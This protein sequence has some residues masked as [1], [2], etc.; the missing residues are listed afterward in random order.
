MCPGYQHHYVPSKYS[1]K[2]DV[3]IE[4]D[5]NPYKGVWDKHLGK[6]I[7][8]TYQEIIF[9][10]RTT[11]SF[12]FNVIFNHSVPSKH[13]FNTTWSKTIVAKEYKQNSNYE[14]IIKFYYKGQQNTTIEKCVG[15]S[16][17]DQYESFDSSYWICLKSSSL[18]PELINVKK[19]CDGIP[20]CADSSDETGAL[21][22]PSYRKFQLIVLGGVTAFVVLG[23]ITFVVLQKGSYVS[24]NIKK[25]AMTNIVYVATEMI[26][27]CLESKEK[28][29][30]RNE[31]LERRHVKKVR[32][33]YTPCRQGEAK[34]HLLKLLYA[35]SLNDKIQNSVWQIMDE[36]IRVEEEAHKTKGE[37]ICCMRF[38]NEAD[39]YLSGFIKD[40]VERYDFLTNLRRKI[41]NFLKIDDGTTS[42]YMDVFIQIV[43]AFLN[44]GMFYYDIVKDI[45]VIYLLSYVHNTLLNDTELTTRFDTVGGMNFRV[46]INYLAI[47]LIFSEAAIYWKI[48]NRKDMFR[49]TFNVDINS[50]VGRYL[51]KV[52]PM[53]FIFLTTCAVKIRVLVLKRQMKSI[54][55]RKHMVQINSVVN[56]VITISDKI[57]ELNKQLYNLNIMES[58]MQVI[59]TALEREPQTMVQLGLFILMKRFKR[60]SLLFNSF[61]GVTIE[62]ISVVTWLVTMFIMTKSVRG[63]LHSKRWPIGPNC[64]GMIVQFLAIS[65]LLLPKLL[66]ISLTLLNAFYLYPFTHA[67][68]LLLILLYNKLFCWNNEKYVHYILVAGIAPA[69]YK[70]SKTYSKSNLIRSCLRILQKYGIVINAVVLQ[71]ITLMIYSTIGA[72]LR[73][74]MFHFNIRKTY[75]INNNIIEDHTN[76]TMPQ[77]VDGMNQNLQG[78]LD[79][80]LFDQPLHNFPIHVIVIYIVCIVIY[81]LLTVIYYRVFHPWKIIIWQNKSKSNA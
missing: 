53:H 4:M 65:V 44:V 70:S 33:I 5:L 46:L 40:V 9:V 34:K 56:D 50:R 3:R 10:S 60:I 37:A 30:R 77:N 11:N 23:I 7:A 17:N 72:I 73:H 43:L 78:Y 68:N 47:V 41:S 20:D 80:I 12:S 27:I 22:K 69:F 57:E 62:T 1:L 66:L 18:N 42:F 14:V 79:I 59:Q 24:D 52:F 31:R 58:E 38:C 32:K 61:F 48:N 36:I 49:E 63:Y 26:S 74:A 19:L 6:V 39:S 67:F 29:Y 55:N 81:V 64:F 8:P 25:G 75:G 13:Y 51:V 15:G 35:M 21:C 71:F 16:I 45:I 76:D 2:Q 28:H 54:L